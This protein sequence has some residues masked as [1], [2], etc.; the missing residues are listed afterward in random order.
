M[1]RLLAPV[2]VLSALALVAP[3]HAG[4]FTYEDPADMPLNGG[5]DIRSAGYSTTGKGSGRAYVPATLVATMS[6]TAAPLDQ[7]GIGYEVAAVVDGCGDV[8]FSYTPGTVGSSVLGE[9]LLFVGCGGTADPTSDAQLLTPKFAVEGG[10][11]T[12]SIGLK[13][14]PKEVRAG[15]VLTELLSRVDVVEPAF[16]TRLVGAAPAVFDTAA[17]DKTWKIS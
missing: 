5:L 15:A 13:A 10:K 16:G 3:S 8:I 6:L 14:L 9:A 7:A 1:R 11:L 17:T 4:S 2:A 12:W